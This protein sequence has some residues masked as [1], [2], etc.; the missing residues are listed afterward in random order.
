MSVLVIVR[1]LASAALALC[2]HQSC[3]SLNVRCASIYT[4]SEH[5]T[6]LLDRMKLFL[7]VSFAVSLAQRCFLWPRLHLNS[8]ASF[9]AVSNIS[10]HLLAH[11][12]HFA[13]YLSGIVLTLLILLPINAKPR[14]STFD[15]PSAG[16]R[17]SSS[18]LITPDV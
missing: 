9:I 17:Y 8:A 16:D 7:T 13:T 10:P 18:N 3:P 4:P 15:S 1:S 5:V 14:L 11:S 12:I 2:I 6:C